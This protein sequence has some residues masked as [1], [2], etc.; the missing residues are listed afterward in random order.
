[1]QQFIEDS[2]GDALEAWAHSSKPE[3]AKSEIDRLVGLAH[4]LG[5]RRRDRWT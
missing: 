3:V 2:V 5:E 1:M 4:E